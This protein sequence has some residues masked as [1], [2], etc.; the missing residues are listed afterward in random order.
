MVRAINELE[1][2]RHLWLS[3]MATYAKRRRQ[4]KKER[5][6]RPRKLDETYSWGWHRLAFCP[7]LDMFP[8]EGLVQV[9][10]KLTS[11]Y[12]VG[13]TDPDRCLVCD[14]WRLPTEACQRCGVATD[15][16]VPRFSEADRLRMADRWRQVWGRTWATPKVWEQI[17]RPLSE[18]RSIPHRVR[19]D[20]DPE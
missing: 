15:E 4:E 1:G 5:R 6:S 20:F 17:E 7:D 19:S 18:R 2:A 8:G 3:H 13:V 11:V 12:S 10:R 9:V 16:Y 14:A